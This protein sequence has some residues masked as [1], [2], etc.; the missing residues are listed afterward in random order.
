M[1]GRRATI[2]TDDPGS[3]VSAT[4]CRF[5]ASGQRRRRLLDSRPAEVST[6]SEV[7]TSSLSLVM[8]QLLR[9]RPINTRRASASAYGENDQA[10]IASDKQCL[11]GAS[12]S[13]AFLGLPTT[14][15][16]SQLF[17]V[18]LQGAV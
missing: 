4:I 13:L 6:N 15:P 3:S 11:C 12:E 2:D 9:R 17:R 8:P 7:D 1:S 14:E 5:S 16:R 18:D 10:E